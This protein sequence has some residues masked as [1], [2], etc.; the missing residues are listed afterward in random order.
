MWLLEN[1]TGSRWYAAVQNTGVILLDFLLAPSYILTYCTK[2][3]SEGIKD[4]FNITEKS[5]DRWFMAFKNVGVILIDF[6][7]LMVNILSIFF[8]KNISYEKH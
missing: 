3:R 8:I 7:L 2:Y 4:S 6:L 5:T 1:Y